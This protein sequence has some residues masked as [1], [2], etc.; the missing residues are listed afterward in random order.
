[1]KQNNTKQWGIGLKKSRSCYADTK[2]NNAKQR[3]QQREIQTVLLVL[4][5]KYFTKK[6][7]NPTQRIVEDMR[8][9][10]VSKIIV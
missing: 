3:F 4:A 1:M 8:G 10:S 7:C 5:A 2:P 6:Q 9:K